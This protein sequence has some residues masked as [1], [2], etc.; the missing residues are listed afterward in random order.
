ML[1]PLLALLL[2]TSCGDDSTA[3]AGSP[4]DAATLDASSPDS[5]DIDAGQEDAGAR[6][7]G[8]V[9][10]DA[11]AGVRSTGCGGDATGSGELEARTLT[12]GGRERTYHLHVPPSYDP[13]V[14]LALVFRFHGTGGTG[15]SGGL[16]VEDVAGGDAIVVGPDG[17][18]NRW[19]DDTQAADL[20]LFDALVAELGATYCVDLERVF[21]TGYSAGGG[22]SN[23]LACERGELLAGAAPIAGYRRG[24]DCDGPVPMWFW[25]DADDPTVLPMWGR[26]ARDRFLDLNGCGD[27]TTPTETVAYDGCS[28]PVTWCETS[29]EGHRLPGGIAARV[30][31]F[32]AAR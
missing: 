15:A 28:E 1:R 5:R 26:Q 7:S 21:V 27:E 19:G 23:L 20:A 30:W 12:A 32:F 16:G 2:L 6:D 17:I 10:T 18:D 25:H 31:A 3:D 24:S 4:R 8:G 14:A 11:G 13:D 29:G 22:M 9:E